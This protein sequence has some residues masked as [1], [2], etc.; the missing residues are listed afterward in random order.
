MRGSNMRYCKSELND[1]GK[2]L[3]QLSDLLQFV[4]SP[5]AASRVWFCRLSKKVL[6]F[7]F[8][9]NWPTTSFSR[10]QLFAERYKSNQARAN[11][12]IRAGFRSRC[13][14]LRAE[15]EV[16]EQFVG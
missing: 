10:N 15:T 9:P 4:G 11:Q 16:V 6:I 14:V 12:Q 13:H 1:A 3:K 2:C 7:W 5:V 8:L